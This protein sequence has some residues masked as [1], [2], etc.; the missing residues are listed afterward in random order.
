MLLTGVFIVIESKLLDN[1]TAKSDASC[2]VFAKKTFPIRVTSGTKPKKFTTTGL[3]KVFIKRIKSIATSD[4]KGLDV[5]TMTCVSLSPANN[6]SAC[7][8]VIP[9]TLSFK[10]LPPVPKA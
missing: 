8:D 10:S 2:K 3:F 4:A 5:K 6:E 1:L 7:F 9:P